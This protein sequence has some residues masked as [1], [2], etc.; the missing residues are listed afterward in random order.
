[1]AYY[2]MGYTN[3]QLRE[4]FEKEHQQLSQT[5]FYAR[6]GKPQFSDP[7]KPPYRFLLDDSTGSSMPS[8]NELRRPNFVDIQERQYTLKS[9]DSDRTLAFVRLNKGITKRENSQQVAFSERQDFP[10]PGETIEWSDGT[11]THQLT[12]KRVVE[13]RLATALIEFQDA[14]PLSTAEQQI[15]PAKE[16]QRLER[17]IASYKRKFKIEEGQEFLSP[18]SAELVT[19]APRAKKDTADPYRLPKIKNIKRL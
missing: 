11:I 17:K 2:E 12:V 9:P 8:Y 13:Q 7:Q 6:F 14:I 1:M 18:E 10:R 4:L 19:R 15:D 16:Q 3:A 5:E